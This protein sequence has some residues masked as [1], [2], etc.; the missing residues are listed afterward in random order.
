MGVQIS[1]EC[2]VLNKAIKAIT[3]SLAP[4]KLIRE[5]GIAFTFNP[6]IMELMASNSFAELDYW[7]CPYNICF[8]IA[9]RLKLLCHNSSGRKR[10][11]HAVFRILGD[12]PFTKIHQ[13]AAFTVDGHAV[14]RGCFDLLAGHSLFKLF[15]VQFRVASTNVDAINIRQP[16]TDGAEEY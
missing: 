1:A 12:Q 11:Y 3:D 15:G 13:P 7:I 4:L 2:A 10:S 6:G 9:Q 5:P 14:Q 8:N 16:I